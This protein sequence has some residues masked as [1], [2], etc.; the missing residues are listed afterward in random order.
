M[1]PVPKASVGMDGAALSAFLKRIRDE[2][3]HPWRFMTVDLTR[4]TPSA[5][6]AEIDE[7]RKL[8]ALAASSLP[9]CRAARKRLK[10]ATNR[11]LAAAL[12]RELPECLQ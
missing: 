6:A 2:L 11:G 8:R 1:R 7:F 9:G 12:G 3:R 10:P 5:P 4:T